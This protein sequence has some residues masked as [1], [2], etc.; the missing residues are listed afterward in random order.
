MIPCVVNNRQGWSEEI[1]LFFYEGQ[2]KIPAI[3]EI[4][5]RYT[6][7]S[8]IGQTIEPKNRWVQGHMVSLLKNKHR[9]IFLQ[10]DFNKCFDNLGNDDFLE[11]HVIQSLPGSTTEERNER[12]L[13]W[14]KEYKKRRTS[15][16]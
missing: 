8:Y 6:N 4:R 11:F 10:R 7:R 12:E 14:L 3:Y 15:P 2:S 13:Y 9:N 5:N 1:M 16:L